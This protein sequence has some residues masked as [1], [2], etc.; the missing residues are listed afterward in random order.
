MC[1]VRVFVG[2]VVMCFIFCSWVRVVGRLGLFCV[3]W[4]WEIF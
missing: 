4:L 1:I 2:L 3:S